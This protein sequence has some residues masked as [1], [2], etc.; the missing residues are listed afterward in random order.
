MPVWPSPSI[1]EAVRAV[2]RSSWVYSELDFRFRSLPKISFRLVTSR[3]PNETKFETKRNNPPQPCP[4]K[5][6]TKRKN[7]EPT[8]GGG[9]ARQRQNVFS[10]KPLFQRLQ[11]TYSSHSATT[12]FIRACR[13][14]SQLSETPSFLSI[15]I[16][17]AEKS[18]LP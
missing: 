12:K 8:A 7:P 10:P 15:A 16:C 18:P 6:K 4:T 14:Y 13:S 2:P 5:R 3:A 9:L 1:W 11:S 17:G